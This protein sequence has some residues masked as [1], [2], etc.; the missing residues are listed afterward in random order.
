MFDPSLIVSGK[1]QSPPRIVLYGPHGIG[2]STF[3]NDAG[4]IFIPT[5]SG[6]D[7]IAVKA[8]FPLATKLGQVHEYLEFLL[9]GKH[10]HYALA[11]DTVDWLERLIFAQV[12]K[13]D[14]K[15][16]DS[17]DE[18]FGGWGHG[19]TA[20]LQ[21]W[22]QLFDK[23][24]EI[25]R[26]RNMLVILLAHSKVS[27]YNDPSHEPYDRYTL[28]LYSSKSVNTPGKIQEWA[29]AVLFA[30]YKSVVREVKST[31]DKNKTE[32]RIAI[33]SGDRVLY[34]QERPAFLAKNRFGMPLEIPFSWAEVVKYL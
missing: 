30:G 28:D 31:K 18:A 27:P 7:Q 1:S 12:I 32:K 33:G 20:A 25:R 21:K 29:D 22:Y 4:A 8:K 3:A 15:D 24:D 16:V 17:I 11:I 5:E 23:L 14:P 13:D 26:V 19:Y 6:L 34:C 9:R 10:D 2:K